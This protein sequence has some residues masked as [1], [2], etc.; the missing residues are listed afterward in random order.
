[1]VNMGTGT[2][3]GTQLTIAGNYV[4][5]NG[6][7]AMNTVFEGDNS[8]TDK[9]V[10]DGGKASG[11]TTLL[12]NGGKTIGN[13][14]QT[15]QGIKV[16]EAQNGGTTTTDAFGLGGRR[17]VAGAYEYQLLRSGEDWVLTSGTSVDPKDPDPKD[18]DPKDPDPKDPEPNYR[19]ETPEYEVIPSMARSMGL[20]MLDTLHRRVGEEENLR[21]NVQPRQGDDKWRGGWSRIIGQEQRNNYT[22]VTNPST[23]GRLNGFQA[24]LDVYRSDAQG[25]EASRDH[26]G[27]YAGYMHMSAAVS[28]DVQSQ[29]QIRAGSVNLD[30]PSL[31]AY[32]TH[33]G[34][35]GWYVDTVLQASQYD[36]AATS[37]LGANLKTTSKSM[38]ASVEAGYPLRFGENDSWLMEPQAQLIWQRVSVSGARDNFSQVDW[39]AGGSIT[40]RLG[41]RLQH[42]RIDEHKNLWQPYARLNLWHSSK[43]TDRVSFDGEAPVEM[44]YGGTSL[45]GALGMTAK[46][47]K[48]TSL[49]TEVGYRRS[50]GSDSQ[51]QRAYSAAAGVRV[52]W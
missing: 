11:N 50:I 51:R 6:T 3:P 27:L 41:L 46:I 31:A 5:N 14:A 4:G 23:N 47:N 26:V 1:M 2:T 44:R 48:T 18:P 29:K 33:F 17:Y 35:K 36:V 22:G 21:G 45:E 8:P 30:G 7:I 12:F 42:T 43:G 20:A 24:G 9:V 52:N 49:Y 10:I 40:G 37:S 28:G 25:E 13:G 19:P 39:G 16:V 34:P 38:V 15:V 32:W